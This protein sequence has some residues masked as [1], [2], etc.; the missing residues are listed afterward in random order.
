MATAADLAGVDAPVGIDGTSLAPILTG[1]G[2][3]KQRNYLVFEQHGVHG[4]DPDPRIGRWTVIRQDGMKL[5]RYDN[6]TQELF[7]LNT[8][9]ERDILRSAC[10]IPTNLAIAQELEADAIADDVTRGT[11]QYRTWSGP[12]GGIAANR[13][14]LGCANRARPILVRRRRQHRCLARDCPRL[15]PM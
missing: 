3:L 8:D 5:I 7:N 6:E 12:N 14:Q 4:D 13:R 10:R 15:R 11:V 1:Q 2:H 9:P